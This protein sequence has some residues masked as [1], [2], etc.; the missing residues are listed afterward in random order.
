MSFAART[1]FGLAQPVASP[2]HPALG[3][4]RATTR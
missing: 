4:A 2:P 3:E 1:G